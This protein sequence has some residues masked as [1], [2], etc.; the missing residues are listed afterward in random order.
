MIRTGGGSIGETTARR[1]VTHGQTG[2]C[3]G[4]TVVVARGRG[5]RRAWSQWDARARG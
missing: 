3:A 4:V 2:P 5:G 1:A